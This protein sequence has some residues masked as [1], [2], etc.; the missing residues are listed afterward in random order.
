MSKYVYAHCKP[1]GKHI[2]RE[3]FS[4][5]DWIFVDDQNRLLNVLKEKRD[6][7]Y[8]FFIHWNWLVPKDI[9]DNYE[10]VC[11]HMTD[12]PYGR[13][14]SP[15]QNLILRGHEKTKLT[16]LRMEQKLDAGPIYVKHDLSLHG[17]A[18]EIYERVTKLA[19]KLLEKIIQGNITPTPQEGEP[20]YFKRRKPEESEIPYGLDAKGI[21]DYIRMLD[22]EGY[23]R[24]F[25]EWD[26]HKLVFYN[27]KYNKEN[28]QMYCET[29]WE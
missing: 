5:D 8:I 1:W 25:R 6:I 19:G 9:T 7:H 2:F 21:Y 24:A 29:V 23:P 20:T 10:C 28:N 12:L 11:F 26:G 14:G 18:Q 13:G 27:A 16:A 15:L 3:Q 17:S 4:S 22:A